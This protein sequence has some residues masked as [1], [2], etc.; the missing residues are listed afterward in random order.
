MGAL[1]TTKDSAKDFTWSSDR[2][3][4]F[5][6]REASREQIPTD[7]H[8]ELR[9]RRNN[10]ARRLWGLIAKSQRYDWYI[11]EIP[12]SRLLSASRVKRLHPLWDARADGSSRSALIRFTASIPAPKHKQVYTHGFHT[13]SAG[14]EDAQCAKA[15]AVV[16]DGAETKDLTLEQSRPTLRRS[17]SEGQL[18]GCKAIGVRDETG[19]ETTRFLS[20]DLYHDSNPD[21][22]TAAI[23]PERTKTNDV[24]GST[25]ENVSVQPGDREA[26]HIPLSYQIPADVKRKVLLTS[27]SSLAAYWHHGLYQGPNGEKV[28]V[29]YCKSKETTERVAQFFLN[30]EVIGFDIEWKPNSRATGGIRYV[31]LCSKHPKNIT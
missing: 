18:F 17:C 7:L 29:H 12:W 16:G 14:A 21:S 4:V 8:Y 9:V 20:S 25:I 28:K 6:T 26:D 27:D 19:Q 10:L 2:G 24:D 1:T 13:A 3:V 23:D 15:D 31:S 5:L 30:Q 11:R 22:R